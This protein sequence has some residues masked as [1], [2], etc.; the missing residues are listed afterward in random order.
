MPADRIATP[1]GALGK[2]QPFFGFDGWPV[3]VRQSLGVRSYLMNDPRGEDVP[4]T[5]VEFGS[6]LHECLR[7][8]YGWP[9]GVRIYAESPR[10]FGGWKV[11]RLEFGV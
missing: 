4:E 6:L 10:D 1:R 5:E 9:K 7:F 8:K 2:E 3:T 11:T